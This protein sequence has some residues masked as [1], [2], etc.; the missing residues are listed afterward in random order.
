MK[1]QT[2]EK[3]IKKYMTLYQEGM[4]AMQLSKSAG[5]SLRG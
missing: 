5:P 4:K 3:D 2:V 1:R